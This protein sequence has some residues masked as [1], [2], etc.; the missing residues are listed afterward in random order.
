MMDMIEK[1]IKKIEMSTIYELRLIITQG[2]KTE[3]TKEEITEL[4][5]KIA[6]SKEQE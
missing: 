3:Y 1:E 5:D 6:T 2:E 4:L